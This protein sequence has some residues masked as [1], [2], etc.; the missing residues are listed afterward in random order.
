MISTL[1]RTSVLVRCRTHGYLSE[2]NF[3]TSDLAAQRASCKACTSARA[4]KPTDDVAAVLRRFKRFAR[5][6]HHG[7]VARWERSD[8]RSILAGLGRG[9]HLR[10]ARHSAEWW[11]PT[12][13][14]VLNSGAARRQPRPKAGRRRNVGLI[15]PT[16]PTAWCDQASVAAR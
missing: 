13:L 5:R 10:P 1:G 2:D 15:E 6:H 16:A 11:C 9:V 14:V 12:K 4:N 7:E 3:F 8:V